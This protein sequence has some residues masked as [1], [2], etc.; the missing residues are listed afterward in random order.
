MQNLVVDTGLVADPLT[1]KLNMEGDFS[2][3]VDQSLLTPA[4]RYNL[5]RQLEC[6]FIYQQEKHEPTEEEIEKLELDEDDLERIKINNA[7]KDEINHM[8]SKFRLVETDHPYFFVN[9]RKITAV[10]NQVKEIRSRGEQVL[11][12]FWFKAELDMLRRMFPNAACILPGQATSKRVK[13][14]SKWNTAAIPILI[15][16]PASMG[17]GL[18]LQGTAENILFTTLPTSYDLYHQAVT[19]VWR[20]FAGAD[21]ITCYSA[22]SDEGYSKI[23]KENLDEREE[24][25]NK[26]LMACEEA[27]KLWI[28]KI[29]KEQ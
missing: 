6:G 24:N 12:C 22:I 25:Q 10:R 2:R 29:K 13:I 19:R 16:N 3:E 17:R 23:V 1:G 15:G 14:I 8:F 18:N 27:T 11:I 5:I 26:F 21:K 7:L 4:G 9:S 20:Q 28:S